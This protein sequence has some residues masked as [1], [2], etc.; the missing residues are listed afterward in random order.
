[1]TVDEFTRL[2]RVASQLA[3]DNEIL[4]ECDRWRYQ[5]SSVSEEITFS[6]VNDPA[7][8]KRQLVIHALIPE[9]QKEEP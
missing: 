9:R 7:A 5:I 4:V 6:N 3:R 1:M 8:I 2:L